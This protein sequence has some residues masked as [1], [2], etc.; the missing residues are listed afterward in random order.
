M[1]ASTSGAVV[2][3]TAG[4]AWTIVHAAATDHANRLMRKAGRTSWNADDS[5][6]HTDRLYQ[7][8]TSWGF[9]D[10]EKPTSLYFAML[11]DRNAPF[12]VSAA[13]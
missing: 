13:A 9:W 7:L 5:D 1:S 2:I 11:A 4:E 10:G 8:L 12:V 6:A 3:K